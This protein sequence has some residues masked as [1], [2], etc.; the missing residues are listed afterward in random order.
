MSKIYIITPSAVVVCSY[1]K[2]VTEPG[3]CITFR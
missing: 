1:K 2:E 3:A